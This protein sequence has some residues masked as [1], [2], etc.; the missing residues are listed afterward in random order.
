MVKVSTWKD[1]WKF[2]LLQFENYKLLMKNGNN[3]IYIF[4][5]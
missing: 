4:I 3:F 1:M 2:L 5:K